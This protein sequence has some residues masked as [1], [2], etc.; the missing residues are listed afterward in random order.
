MEIKYYG[1]DEASGNVFVAQT[2]MDAGDVVGNH[3]HPHAHTSELVYG[4]VRLTVGDKVEV[5]EGNGVIRNIPAHVHHRVEALAPSKWNCIWDASLVDMD[6]A[7][8]A[9]NLVTH[10][11][12]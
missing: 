11:H 5:V 4:C 7:K 1:G 3:S 10:G 12:A 6:E 2:T 8:N 9:L